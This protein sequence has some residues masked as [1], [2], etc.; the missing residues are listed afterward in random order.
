MLTN[1]T[2]EEVRYIRALEKLWDMLSDAVEGGRLKKEDIPDDYEALVGQMVE[3]EVARYAANRNQS[4]E[5][6]KPILTDEEV[7][8]IRSMSVYWNEVRER[9]DRTPLVFE[10]NQVVRM[11]GAKILW[12]VAAH[13]ER[14]A[15]A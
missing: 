3:C 15:G 9:E 12:I 7:R 1:L 14:E 2:P 13:A 8:T 10:L 4:A 11:L 5:S 6:R